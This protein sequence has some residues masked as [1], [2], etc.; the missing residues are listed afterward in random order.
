MATIKKMDRAKQYIDEIYEKYEN[1]RKYVQITIHKFLFLKLV[2]VQVDKG[3]ESR[4]FRNGADEQTYW[5]AVEPR[6]AFVA[7]M[8]KAGMKQTIIAKCLKFS[9]GT[10]NKDVAYLRDY[11]PE[12]LEG[13][14]L[15]PRR[16]EEPT[17]RR[18]T[19]TN[20]AGV[21]LQ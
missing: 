16:G 8:L 21:T 3:Y 13:V 14:K 2:V 9:A 17:V 19:R 11:Q 4:L 5:M 7:K 10:I 1:S 6:R 15:R 18:I 20:Q 12:L